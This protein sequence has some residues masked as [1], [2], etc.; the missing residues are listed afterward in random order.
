VRPASCK[1]SGHRGGPEAAA[2]CRRRASST[3]RP[4][5]SVCMSLVHRSGLQEAGLGGYEADMSGEG[6]LRLRHPFVV[7]CKIDLEHL[8]VS[9]SQARL[10]GVPRTRR[11]VVKLSC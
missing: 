4:F 3:H 5:I 10:P 8:R 7:Q 1:A 11:Q 6:S 9:A 2:C